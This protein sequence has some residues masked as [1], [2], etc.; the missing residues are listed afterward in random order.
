MP[1]KKSPVVT[2]PV[3]AATPAPKAEK[4]V[5]A[6]VEKVVVPVVAAVEEDVVVESPL[7]TLEDK[8]SLLASTLKEVNVQ[9]RVVKKELDRLRR[10]ADRV[11]R[12]RANART[13]PNGFAKPT[14]ISDELCVFLGVPKGSEKSRTEVTREIHKYVKGKE[15]S[16]PKNKRIILAAKDATLKKLLACSDADEISY[17]NLQKFL[18]HHFVKAVVA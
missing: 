10:I 18:K 8:L 15:L 17:F 7:A 4:V 14:K 13:T 11:E 5:A 2:A 9:V 16:D 3:V 12:K 1:A 6:K